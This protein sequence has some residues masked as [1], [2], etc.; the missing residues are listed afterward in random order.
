VAVESESKMVVD[1]EREG[2]RAT[3]A[4]DLSRSH[5]FRALMP[6]LCWSSPLLKATADGLSLAVGIAHQ[7]KL[8]TNDE[9]VLK[10]QKFPPPE[11]L[12]ILSSSSILLRLTGLFEGKQIPT[13]T[14][15]QSSLVAYL[16][17]YL[18]YVWND[19]AIWRIHSL[20][21]HS[22]QHAAK[23]F[24]GNVS[25][26]YVSADGTLERACFAE[27]SWFTH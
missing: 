21:S 20:L 7:L 15:Q 8:A 1:G 19:P 2:G 25:D 22:S 10:I 4:D 27:S 18:K 14:L 23:L 9:P 11:S 24:I 17:E 13:E 16:L 5:H 6:T 3:W 26:P 12:D